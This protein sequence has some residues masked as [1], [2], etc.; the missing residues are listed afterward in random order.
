M[1]SPRPTPALST[2]RA[3]LR[4]FTT[5]AFLLVPWTLAAA[6]PEKSGSAEP[7]ENAEPPVAE[8]ATK[9]I[10]A[11]LVKQVLGCWQLDGQE[12]WVIK[13]LDL[14]GAQ[15]AT[16]LMKNKGHAGFPD[17][18]RRAAV[19][20]TLMYDAHAGNFGFGVA[21]RVRPTLVLFKLSGATLEATLYAKKSPKDR[22][23]PTGNQAT[24]QRCK[25]APRPGPSPAKPTPPRLD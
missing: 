17:Y 7:A 25:A 11:R 2:G 6:E 21:G 13:R 9:K 18:I 1:H 23:A 3:G 14:N 10:P 5:L 4:A 19:P 24:L 15:V 16:T 20:A 12:R 8:K 22:F